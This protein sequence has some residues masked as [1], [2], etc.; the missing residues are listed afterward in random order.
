MRRLL[1]DVADDRPLGDVT[2]LLDATVV[3]SMKD[4]IAEGGTRRNSLAP[5][6]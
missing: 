6:W 5:S 1:C 3:D 4:H 2:T